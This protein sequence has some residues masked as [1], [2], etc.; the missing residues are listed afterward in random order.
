[1]SC[2]VLRLLSV[3]VNF[4]R[5]HIC[6]L[7]ELPRSLCRVRS[8]V[9]L[10][11]YI[12]LAMFTRHVWQ[13]QQSNVHV[14]A[15]PLAL[16]V[17]SVVQIFLIASSNALREEYPSVDAYVYFS[18]LTL[19]TLFMVFFNQYNYSRL[20]MW[21]ILL[22]I[23]LL[24]FSVAAHISSYYPS[25]IF[26][27]LLLTLMGEYILIAALG[28]ALQTLLKRFEAKLMHAKRRDVRGLFRF[29]FT[30]GARAATGLQE[31]YQNNQIARRRTTSIAESDVVIEI[32]TSN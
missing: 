32:R 30:W 4:W 29:A 9:A 1:M 28:L 10:L 16:V 23:S 6:G 19:L 18:T 5:L 3:L 21:Q 2:S 8:A 22:T 31:F 15:V 11:L 17:K 20:N 26:S 7:Q 25:D 13:D 14:K 24:S 27:P 12:P